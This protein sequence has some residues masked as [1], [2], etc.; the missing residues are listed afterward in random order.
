MNFSFTWP[1]I[2]CLLNRDSVPGFVRE[3]S[4]LALGSSRFG[5]RALSVSLSLFN[6]FSGIFP[7]LKVA[8]LYAPCMWVVSRATGLKEPLGWESKKMKISKSPSSPESVPRDP[9]GEV[10]LSPQAE[11]DIPERDRWTPFRLVAP[12]SP[13]GGMLNLAFQGQRRWEGSARGLEGIER[14][15]LEERVRDSEIS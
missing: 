5:F 14:V 8:A 2:Q 4:V 3:A 11:E 9:R 13:L 10:Q 15:A 7:P 1:F 6:Y 12:G